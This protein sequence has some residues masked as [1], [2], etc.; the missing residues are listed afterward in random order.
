MAKNEFL[1]FGIGNGA[2]VL[3]PTDWLALSSRNAGFATGIAKSKEM[4]TALRQSS[5]I[6]NVVAQF[7]ADNSGKDVLDNGDL[8]TLQKNLSAA[9]LNSVSGR[10]LNTQTFTASGTYIPTTGTKRIRAKV[11][12]AGGGGQGM[13]S[14]S[15]NSGAVGGGGG[16][17]AESLI[18]VTGVTSISVTVGTGGTATVAGN[19]SNGGNGGKSLFGKHITCEGGLGGNQGSIAPVQATGGTIINI[20]GQ[21]A[22]GGVILSGGIIVGGVG[23][24]SFGS[25]SANP[26]ISIPS[27][28]GQFP[29]GGGAMGT[30]IS[31]TQL[32]PSGMGANG[33]VI[34][35]E[36]S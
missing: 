7:I 14:T 21:V 11:W 9:L 31:A 19:N 4:N 5:V 33:Y 16:A 3:N 25:A 2:N 26:H 23:G 15:I 6:T 1:P 35:E 30:Y 13:S 34:V 27:D 36:Y 29:G 12:G 22:Q 8:S 24:G 18:D 17:Y 28:N 32:Q 20:S 10:L